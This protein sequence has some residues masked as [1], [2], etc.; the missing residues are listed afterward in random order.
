MEDEEVVIGKGA[1]SGKIDRWMTKL[2]EGVA[3]LK[4]YVGRNFSVKHDSYFSHRL[5]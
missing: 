5:R 2:E 4:G 3:D 1:I